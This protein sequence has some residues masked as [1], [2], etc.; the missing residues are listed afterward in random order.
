MRPESHADAIFRLHASRRFH[1]LNEAVALRLR[2]VARGLALL[3]FLVA[4]ATGPQ[5]LGVAWYVALAVLSAMIVTELELVASAV[6]PRHRRMREACADLLSTASDHDVVE[7][8]VAVSRLLEGAPAGFRS[9]RAVA[10]NDTVAR[11]VYSLAQPVSWTARGL[12]LLAGPVRA[13]PPRIQPEPYPLPAIEY[14]AE[15]IHRRA[16]QWTR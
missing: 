9:L 6:I 14:R 2:Q 12:A 8:S 1:E 15:P 7:L 16:D 5:S 4:L 11:Q 10:H 3:A 13:A